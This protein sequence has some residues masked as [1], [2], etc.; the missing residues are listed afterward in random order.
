MAEKNTNASKIAELKA[1]VHKH[2][3]HI[4]SAAGDKVISSKEWYSILTNDAA[5]KKPPEFNPT[6]AMAISSYAAA[7]E[8]ERLSRQYGT[9]RESHFGFTYRPMED[10]T[11]MKELFETI[12]NIV[13]ATATYCECDTIDLSTLVKSL[14]G[15]DVDVVVETETI[16]KLNWMFKRVQFLCS[17]MLR[18]NGYDYIPKFFSVTAKKN[19]IIIGN[20]LVTA[21]ISKVFGDDNDITITDGRYITITDD[22]MVIKFTPTVPTVGEIYKDD[23]DYCLVSFYDAIKNLV[24]EMYYEES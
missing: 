4:T 5:T 13:F 12:D 23:D 14:V 3:V 15:N 7:A 9:E 19:D 6:A 2:D 16:N 1:R 21:D 18:D 22:G 20:W 11:R 10:I 8:G 17:D 24:T